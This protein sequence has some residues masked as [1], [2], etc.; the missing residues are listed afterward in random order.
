M[1][2]YADEYNNSGFDFQLPVTGFGSYVRGIL[3][4]SEAVLAGAFGVSMQQ[5]K[6]IQNV[7]LERFAQVVYSL[8]TNEGL[9]LT[10]GTNVPADKFLVDQALSKIALGSDVYG[11][12]NMSN[13][14]GCMS[15]LPYPLQDILTGIRQ[16]ETVKLYNIYDQMYLA[17]KWEQATAVATVGTDGSNYFLQ[18]L[19]GFTGCGYGRGSAPP[20]TISITD[21]AGFNPTA[22]LEIGT[23]P[24]DISTYGKIKGYSITNFGTQSTAPG[25]LIITIQAPPTASLP[26]QVDGNVATGGVNTPVGTAGWPGMNT[27]IQNYIDQANAEITAIQNASQENFQKAKVLN[28]NYNILGTMLKIEQRSRY[29]G[30]PAAPIPYYDALIP[31]PQSLYGF[32]DSLP[33][34]A[35][36]TNPNGPV[37]NLE[38]VADFCSPAGQSLVG[39]MRQ[40]RN[41]ARLNLVGLTLDNNISTQVEPEIAK[42]KLV[43]GT[44]PDAV[45]GVQSD[46]GVNYTVPAWSATNRCDST[47]VEP[48][49]IAYFD[50]IINDIRLTDDVQPGNIISILQDDNPVVATEV[51]RGIGIPAIG[52]PGAPPN[53]IPTEGIQTIGLFPIVNVLPPNLDKRYISSTV[54]PSSYN[55]QTAIDKVIE[56]NCDCWIN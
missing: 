31:F 21:G 38:T 14:F 5:I 43:N 49:P 12:Y 45:E 4:E 23:D 28:T 16:L 20:P 41:Q 44:V 35:Q 26:V 7:N 11:T 34:L 30:R 50:P 46:N 56:C 47:T 37:Q 55:V 54:L 36:E 17:V 27:V 2:S 24:T 8:E 25:S 15:G 1:A 3:P 42:T 53:T 9:P 33:F 40:E 19:S 32:V 10:N 52:V 48:M 22:Q 39:M 6:N 51:P 13:F 18:S 29:I